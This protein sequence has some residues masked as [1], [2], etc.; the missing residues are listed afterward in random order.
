MPLIQ[1]VMQNLGVKKEGVLVGGES[2]IRI[3]RDIL[4][5]GGIVVAGDSIEKYFT[6]N[7]VK[8]GGDALLNSIFNI[9]VTG[10]A[11][12]GGSS[13]IQFSKVYKTSNNYSIGDLINYCNSTGIVVGF[14]LS[15]YSEAEYVI[16]KF[17]KRIIIKE[18]EI[19]GLQIGLD[20]NLIQTKIN[21]INYLINNPKNYNVVDGQIVLENQEQKF[22]YFCENEISNKINK[23]SNFVKNYPVFKNKTIVQESFEPCRSVLSSSTIDKKLRDLSK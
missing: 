22:K 13:K 20:P 23:M 11:E 9:L 8:V 7:G 16:S 3:V 5:S 19:S 15:S 6:S 21:Y 12:V 18:S 4:I 2:Q 10:G 14:S 1:W 17:S